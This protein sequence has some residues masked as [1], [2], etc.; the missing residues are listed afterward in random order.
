[1]GS[2]DMCHASQVPNIFFPGGHQSHFGPQ[3]PIQIVGVDA[4]ACVESCTMKA[5]HKKDEGRKENKR[6]PN[7]MV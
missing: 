4:C 3:H 5:N 6:K 7:Q 1:M 2:I